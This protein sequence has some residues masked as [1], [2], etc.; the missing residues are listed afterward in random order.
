MLHILALYNKNVTVS[1]QMVLMPDFSSA[2]ITCMRWSSAHSSR[3]S[4]T[5]RWVGY[6]WTIC[7][8]E[9]SCAWYDVDHGHFQYDRIYICG[10]DWKLTLL[11]QRRVEKK[12]MLCTSHYIELANHLECHYIHH[13]Q[14]MLLIFRIPLE[15][16]LLCIDNSPNFRMNLVLK[17]VNLSQ[18]A[19]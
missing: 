11:A 9:S 19:M 16:T 8:T 12:I 18:A 14:I 10:S 1:P 6:G 2:K 4:I 3:H 17:Y 15:R 7:L 5:L 13:C